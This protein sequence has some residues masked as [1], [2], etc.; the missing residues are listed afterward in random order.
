MTVIEELGN[1]FE[2]ESQ[3]LLVLDTKEIADPAA[4]E[5][6]RSAERIGKEQFDAFTKECLI[7]RS[8]SIDETIH[9][10][11]LPLFGTSRRTASK[12]KQ[13][14][15]SLKNDVALFSRLYISCQTRDGNLEEFFRHE[16]QACP[17][18]LS[19]AGR[20]HLGTKS[21]L[22]M[23][24]EGLSEAQ[25]EAPSVTNVVLDGAAIIQMLKP[26][27]AKTF[28]EYA[29]QVFL[30]YISGQL[31]HVTRLDLVWDS[32]VVDSL[33]ATAR[34]KR[35]KG[36]RRRVV[37][38]APIPGN[39][40][41][42]LR[43][44][45]N[46][47][48]LFSFLSKALIQ[49]FD[50][51]NKELVVTDGE[52]V[53]CV[54]PQQ[55]IHSL[56]PC[57]HEEADSRMLL[58]VAHAAQYGHNRILIRTVDTD[59]VV[60][61]VMVAQ[62]L[63]AEDE[64][65]LAFGT[66]KSFRYLAAHRIAAYLG[67]EK[68]RALPMFHALTGCDTVSAFIGN[69]KKTAWAAWNSLPELTD[70]LLQLACAPTEIPEHS[71]QAIERFVI[72][73]YDRTSTCTNVNKARK[74]LFAKRS[75]VQRIP[76]TRAALEQ[77]VKRAVFQGGHVWGQTLVTQPVLP[78]PSSWG[79]IKNDDGLYEPHW[80][81]LPEASKTCYELVSCGCKKGCRSRCKCRKAAL[82]CTALCHCEGECST[83]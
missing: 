74:K 64:V 51:D 10:N 62:T 11:K 24:L 17:P 12:G 59:V 32:Y 57:S 25:S 60:L 6:V 18:S 1:P 21:D 31:R 50:E 67:P 54:P 16:N 34:E 37:G 80:S 15:T 61:A 19:D 46:K 14:L 63:P 47:Q 52:L 33:K 45:L 79:W 58:H 23:C 56:A 39:W 55:D 71:M 9:R 28:E 83:N 82:Q 7:H 27:A 44:D 26:G 35:G 38:S 77:H 81:T 72:L 30:P 41:N 68:S 5:T 42:F 40:R 73:M 29:R 78:S 2:E 20:L 13:Q 53:L 22:L 76:P 70:A 8:K 65:W 49:S 66:G 3:D 48:E 69:G 75:S 43:V 36:V 4:V